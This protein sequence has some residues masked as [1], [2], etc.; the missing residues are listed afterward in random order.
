MELTDH[1]EQGQG[2]QTGR[3]DQTRRDEM[4]HQTAAL[5]VFQS[6]PQMGAPDGSHRDTQMYLSRGLGD[7][8][9]GTGPNVEGA[10]LFLE[11][12]AALRWKL[13]AAV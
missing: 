7:S 3:S 10:R 9:R 6:H 11:T 8:E 12:A 13:E 2:G 4:H 1:E 5:P